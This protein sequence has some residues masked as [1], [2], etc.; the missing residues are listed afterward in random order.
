MVMILLCQMASGSIPRDREAKVTV[1]WTK[2]NLAMPRKCEPRVRFNDPTVI[3]AIGDPGWPR[4]F[5]FRLEVNRSDSRA[6]SLGSSNAA[7]P[8]PPQL[9]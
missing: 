6:L 5:Y 3:T 2:K 4:G 8:A 9:L 1:A 7:L